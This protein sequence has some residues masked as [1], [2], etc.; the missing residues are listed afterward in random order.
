LPASLSI[1]SSAAGTI[2]SGQSVSFSATPVNGGTLPAYQ[3]KK[4]GNIISGE[5][6]SAYTTNLLAS[7]DT[8][9]CVL[10]SSYP[11]V[12]GNPA[13]SNKI[14]I[15]VFPFCGT[16]TDID[17]NIYHTV[18]IGT[19]C[20][21]VE[22]IRTRRF[23]D[24]TNIPVIP[25]SLLWNGLTSSGCCSYNNNLLNDSIFGLLY[26]WWAINDSRNIC[27]QGWHVATD[28][29]FTVL[30][31][32]LG[33]E[34]IAGGKMKETGNIHWQTPN[35]GANNEVGFTALPAG[36]RN[37]SSDFGYLFQYGVWWCSSE[38]SAWHAW[39]RYTTYN[40]INL[41]R[42]YQGKKNGYSVRL[43]KD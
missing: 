24:G 26:N 15:N 1:T 39:A 12:T 2:Y 30:T 35:S 20:W 38:Y 8:I 17:G 28:G 5:I 16:V 10:F 18:Q 25:D 21:M 9:N 13:V 11:C 33:G 19:Q 7:G 43:V 29:D 4:N 41:V 31:N 6:L 3:W 42:D 36:Y 34:S 32:Y 23:R 40:S 22:N 37:S 27:P 14:A